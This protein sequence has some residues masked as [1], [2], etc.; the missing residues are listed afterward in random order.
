MELRSTLIRAGVLA[1]AAALTAAGTAAAGD[2]DGYGPDGHRHR[3][4]E[5]RVT[6][7]G[8]L[9]LRD[10][11]HRGSAVLRVAE[12]GEIVHIFCRAEGERVDGDKHWYLL[13]DGTWAWGSAQHIDTHE[14]PR[15]C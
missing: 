5:G 13:T 14:R 15:R 10:A 3:T 6:A 1:A 9:L 11:P 4:Y 2:D 8:G 12:R 7:H